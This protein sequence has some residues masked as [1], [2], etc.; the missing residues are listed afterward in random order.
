[1]RSMDEP[2]RRAG[3]MAD[4]RSAIGEAQQAIATRTVS[5]ID[6]P[7]EYQRAVGEH[8]G[9]RRALDIVNETMKRYMTDE[10]DDDA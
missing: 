4:V 9:L 6:N 8:R 5:G 7:A 10:E 3:F 1:M 2:M